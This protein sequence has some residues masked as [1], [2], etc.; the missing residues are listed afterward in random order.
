MAISN[1]L[2]KNKFTTSSVLV[3]IFL[4]NL[5]GS[6]F[7]TN[8][9]QDDVAELEPSYF[10][11]FICAFGW[12]DQHP[13]F[14]A[15]V[16]VFSR[17][18]DSPEYITSLLII[19]FGVM[20]I[21][22]F[23]DLLE[24]VFSYYFAVLGTV[25]FITSP[26]FN[27]YSIGLKQYNFELF[28]S[29][30]CLWL[31]DK[32]SHKELSKKDF[33]P[34]ALASLVLFLFSFVNILPLLLLFIFIIKKSNIKN[35][36]YLSLPAA[37]IFIF[38]GELLDKIERVSQG[39]YWAKHFINTGSFTEYIIS[40]YY[41]NHAFLKS[42]FPYTLH[43]TTVFLFLFAITLLIKKNNLITLYSFSAI[44][45]L[46]ILSSSSLYPIGGGRTD[47]LFLPFTII[48][49]LNALEFLLSKFTQLSDYKF[50]LYF[51]SI[52]LIFT[53][54]TTTTYY[55]NEPINPILSELEESYNNGNIALL[56]T[57]EQ[58]HSFLY[59]SKKLY[60]LG[61]YPTGNCSFE[62][63][64][65]NLFISKNFEIIKPIFEVKE[66]PEAALLGIELPNTIGK[67]RVVSEQLLNEGYFLIEEKTY[68]GS[69]KLLYFKKG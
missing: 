47:L 20:A 3:L 66:Y 12:G 67:L 53:L 55:K 31:L 60:G 59:Y 10:D 4:L 58:S 65:E 25:I 5:R 45:L 64:I 8:Y 32:F 18:F 57:E 22:L 7:P 35:L 44:F 61:N 68:P 13:L 15:L 42:F 34:I 11:S 9:Q 19:T 6:L 51:A 16:W 54:A 63:N 1:K 50:L 39:G 37:L 46:Y 33:T 38:Q 2:N 52:Y 27:T 30:L 48:L 56:V 62:S 41:L 69:L 24:R 40:F 29:V 49:I 23:F 14:S 36:Y 26:V 28:T 43:S 17:F 21:L